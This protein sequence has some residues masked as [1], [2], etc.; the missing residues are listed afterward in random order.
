MFTSGKDQIN[1]A[2]YVKMRD[3]LINKRAVDEF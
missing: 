2:K 3:D 1:Y